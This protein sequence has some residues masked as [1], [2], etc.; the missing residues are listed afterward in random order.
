MGPIC[1]NG[2]LHAA[3]DSSGGEIRGLGDGVRGRRIAVVG[4][5]VVGLL[6]GLFAHHHGAAEVVV[7]DATPARRAAAE[8]LGLGTLDPDVADPAVVLKSRW[9]HGP[10]DRGADVVFQCRGRT[11]ALA[12]ALRLLRPQATVIDLAFYTDDGSALQLG[13]EFH[14]NGLGIRCAQIGRV[15]RGTTHQWDRERLSAETIDVLVA[16]GTRIREAMITDVVPFED[17]PNLLT[18]LA[19]RRRHAIQA[20]LQF[21]HG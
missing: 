19:A 2:L 6:T 8:A 4:G 14:H 5:G 7:L 9:R 3:A 13:A 15:P 12:T 17:G 1:A 16:E 18:D 21:D 10:G 11:A 20:V